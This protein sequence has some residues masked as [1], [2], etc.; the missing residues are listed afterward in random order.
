VTALYTVATTYNQLHEYLEIIFIG[1]IYIFL[2]I[3][4]NYIPRRP[5]ILR[6]IFFSNTYITF[7]IYVIE[8]TKGAIPQ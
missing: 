3:E 4:L 6:G 7:I 5:N 2:I 8:Y 1:Y